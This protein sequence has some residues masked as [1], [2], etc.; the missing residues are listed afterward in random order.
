MYGIGRNYL[1]HAREMNAP[2]PSEPLIFLKP[3]NA[4]V[5]TGSTI[6]LPTFSTL[7]HF[8]VE[9]VV[10]I[11][12]DALCIPATKALEHIAG[13]AVGIDLTLRDIQ[14][15]AKQQGTPW[16]VAK[17]FLGSGPI[18][19]YIPFNP[20]VPLSSLEITL[21]VNGTERQHGFVRNM[22]RPVPELVSH[23]SH[24]FGLRKGDCIFTGTPAGVGPLSAGDRLEAHL[25][26]FTTLSLAIAQSPGEQET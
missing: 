15:R 5:P 10:I 11:S 3:P 12:H 20:E 2:I 6:Y 1:D 9:L 8:E 14:E 17:G 4:Y 22:E 7:V 23:L 26:D 16:A 21:S 13:L 25:N 19:P 24:V 18:S